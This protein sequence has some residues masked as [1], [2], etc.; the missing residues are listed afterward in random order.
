MRDLQS[1]LQSWMDD[2]SNGFAVGSSETAY[3][4][5]VGSNVKITA[6]NGSPRPSGLTPDCIFLGKAVQFTDAPGDEVYAYSLFGQRADS[7]G[8]LYSN[9]RDTGPTPATGSMGSGTAMLTESYTLQNGTVLKRVMNSSGV[10]G[11]NSHLAG[12]YLSLNTDNVI[13]QNGQTDLIA[14]QY[15]VGN[16][17]NMNDPQIVN[18]LRGVGGVCGFLPS[19]F[20]NALSNWQLCFKNNGNGETAQLTIRASANGFNPQVKLDFLAC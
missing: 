3:C 19:G 12:F 6:L 11:N 17:P 13:G 1:Q 7:S 18:C 9:I 2:V 15:P 4:Q 8:N 5:A 16:Q 10:G 20:P 14:Y